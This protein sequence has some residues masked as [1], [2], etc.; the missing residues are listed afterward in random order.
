MPNMFSGKQS[1]EVFFNERKPGS[2]E[3]AEMI[4]PTPRF[5]IN[6][7]FL[8]VL[9]ALAICNAHINALGG[10]MARWLPR[11]L[12][13]QDRFPVEPR[14]HRFILYMHEAV[15]GCDQ[16]IGSTVSDVIVRS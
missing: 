7:I 3:G 1:F 5:E 4:S 11:M 12:K 6:Y 14:L 10:R 15:R 9:N 8:H 16:L 2:M 13:L